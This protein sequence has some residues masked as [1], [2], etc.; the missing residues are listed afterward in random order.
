MIRNFDTQTSITDITKTNSFKLYPNP[1]KDNIA[2]ESSNSIDYVVI[3]DLL[4]R[5]VFEKYNSINNNLTVS[6]EN[7]SS[8]VYFVEVHS[9][10][11]SQTKK[12]VIIE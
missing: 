4:G 9:N 10:G 7:F 11:V 12:L 3:R 6:L 2:I 1:A 5:I 8:D